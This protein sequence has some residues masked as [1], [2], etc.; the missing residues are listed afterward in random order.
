MSVKN[1]GRVAIGVPN[2]DEMLHVD[3]NIKWGN[4]LLRVDEGGS[5]E[6]GGASSSPY[7]DFKNDASSDY[8]VRLSLTGN[9]TLEIAGGTLLVAEPTMPGEV[10]TKNYVDQTQLQFVEV[11]NSNMTDVNISGGTV[12][13]FSTTVNHNTDTTLFVPIA[14]GV[15][16]A[17]AGTYEVMT[18]LYVTSTVQRA[19]IGV[20]ITVNG[21][22]QGIKGAGTYIRSQ[23]GHNESSAHVSQIL[24]VSTGD[25]IGVQSERLAQ[26]GSVELPAGNSNL[27]IKKLR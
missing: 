11:T 12:V 1:N 19:N 5:I 20:E 21:S 9:D 4:G 27:I 3:G 7:I 24:T 18:N 25:V 13:A 26:S 10:A 6:L 23:N 22:P 2:P 14:N 17:E 16:V 8:D 15:Q